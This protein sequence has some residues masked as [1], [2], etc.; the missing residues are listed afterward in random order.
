MSVIVL[1]NY[2]V[3]FGIGVYFESFYSGEVMGDNNIGVWV[4]SY[5]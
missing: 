2:F 5:W 1:C 3:L 4:I